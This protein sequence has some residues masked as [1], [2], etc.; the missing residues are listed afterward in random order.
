MIRLLQT[1]IFGFYYLH[2]MLGLISLEN[3]CRGKKVG[4]AYVR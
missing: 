4:S 2:R 3:A 1:E